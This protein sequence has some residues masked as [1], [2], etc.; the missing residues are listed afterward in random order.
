MEGILEQFNSIDKLQNLAMF[1]L[2]YSFA[3]W[4]LESIVKTVVAKRFV[5]SGFLYGPVCPI[6]GFGAI[7]ILLFINPF[8]GKY[9]IVLLLS[10]F[11]MSIWEYVVGVWLEKKYKTSYWD[12]SDRKFNING[13]VCLGN[14]IF[15]GILGLV[16][17]EFLH[18]FVAGK[19]E[20]LNGNVKAIFIAISYL[21]FL[22][23][24]EISN[25]KVNS[26]NTNLLKLE[27]LVD[28]LKE[29]IDE[30]KDVKDRNREGYEQ[31]IQ[32]SI[33][34]LREKQ[35]VLIETIAKKTKRLKNAF[36]K[37]KSINFHEYLNLVN[38]NIKLKINKK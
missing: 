4:V 35:A 23:D 24:V 14:S 11:I 13:K 9:I 17:V 27:N 1:F 19:V 16:F 3:G 5:N 21:I 30:L 32:N 36:P 6:Y 12:Y 34:E 31:R 38:D 33:N 15:W 26:I 22:I 20:I 25:N 28:R 2:I 18:P 37:M 8:K 10:F 7:G 29:K